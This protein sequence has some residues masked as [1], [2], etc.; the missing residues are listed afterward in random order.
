MR[1]DYKCILFKH[2]QD[3]DIN[4]YSGWC[5]IHRLHSSHHINYESYKV[6]DA[7]YFI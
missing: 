6:Y 5:T 1:R 4:T 2:N 7:S 3:V